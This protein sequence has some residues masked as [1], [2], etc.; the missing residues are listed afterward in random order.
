MV[1]MDKKL[2][3]IIK[4][5]LLKLFFQIKY[6]NSKKYLYKSDLILIESGFEFEYHSKKFN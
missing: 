3:K 2:Y 4:N 6:V 1:F 5:F